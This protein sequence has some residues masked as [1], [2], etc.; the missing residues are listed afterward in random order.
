MTVP[1]LRRSLARALAATAAPMALY[2]AWV[3]LVYDGI[4]PALVPFALVSIIGAALAIAGAVGRSDV[5]L[6]AGLL[7]Q[8]ACPAG[9]AWIAAAVEAVA[10]AILLGRVLVGRARAPSRTGGADWDGSE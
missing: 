5:L 10:G 1:A 6:G 7:L 2:G 9:F 3:A 8:I 4:I